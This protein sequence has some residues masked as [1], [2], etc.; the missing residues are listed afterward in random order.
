MNKEY[1][2]L[3]RDLS[4]KLGKSSEFLMGYQF[5]NGI[6]CKTNPQIVYDLYLSSIIEDDELLAKVKIIAEEI[7]L[8]K[9][10][11]KFG[12]HLRDENL[13]TSNEYL[14]KIFERIFEDRNR[15]ISTNTTRIYR[16]IIDQ[17]PIWLKSS[18]I[19]PRERRL[20]Y[21]R[22]KLDRYWKS[23]YGEDYNG[24]HI[25]HDTDNN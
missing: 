23:K 4:I 3:R 17:Y 24:I 25:N 21:I 12:C 2:Q 7:E 9:M 14:Y 10:T 18:N 5:K 1:V 8:N 6:D 13:I 22:T 15:K 16:N 11:Y 19:T 20:K